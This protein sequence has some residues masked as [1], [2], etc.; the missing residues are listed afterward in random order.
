MQPVPIPT[1]HSFLEQWHQW[2]YAKVARSFKRDRERISDTVQNVRVRLLAKDFIG[3]WFYKHLASLEHDKDEL[4][5]RIQAER[6]LGGAKLIYIGS[7]YPVEGK[8]S[9]PRSLWSVCDLLRYAKFDYERYYYS[10]QNHTINSAKVLRLLG[11]GP[12]EFEA[13]ASLYRQGRLRPAEFTEHICSGKKCPTCERGRASLK[14]RGISLANRWTNPDVM[15]E[16]RKLRWNDG[17]LEGL[18]RNWRRKNMVATTPLEVMRETNLSVDAGLLKYAEILIRNEVTNDFKRM[19][20]TDDLTRTLFKNGTPAQFA[21]EDSDE[22]FLSPQN[23][24]SETVAWGFEEDEP[25]SRIFLDAEAKAD[26]EEVEAKK[27]VIALVEKADLSEE[28]YDAI[29]AVDLMEMTIR[30]YAEQVDKPVPRIHRVRNAAMKK[31]RGN[32]PTPA[33]IESLVE[34]TC[35]TF[36]CSREEL[37]GLSKIGRTVVARARLFST[38]HDK[39]MSVMD[40]QEYFAYPEDRIVAAINR[41]CLSEMRN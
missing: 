5:D 3:R 6:I 16:V 30:Q 31:L 12:D 11:Y 40:M 13:L 36:D 15:D 7:L 18:L 25:P 38:L 4:V 27:D 28:E 34:S 8:R 21:K 32:G 22:V 24:N 20:R 1:N 37:L 2:V 33:M 19:A 10:I 39:G 9:D 17:Q 14:A 23:S 35:K 41:Q 26:F 29:V